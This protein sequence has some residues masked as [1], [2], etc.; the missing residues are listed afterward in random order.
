MTF[1]VGPE[2]TLTE[3]LPENY[4]WPEKPEDFIYQMKRRYRRIA[5]SI[6]NREI[7]DYLAYTPD[8]NGTATTI[9]VLTGQQWY[10]FQSTSSTYTQT[11][12]RTPYRKLVRFPNPLVLG[13]NTQAHNIPMGNPTTYVF[14]KIEGIIFR[15][16]APNP[17]FVPVPNDDIHLEV[18]NTN[19]LLTVPAAYVGFECDA[20][21]LEYIKTNP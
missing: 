8:Q 20:I 3:F 9:E 19:V 16:G 7:A 2:N 15:Q 4:E 5:S 1:D 11:P 12:S 10:Q 14:T 13:L 18:D 6:N 21:V 17:L